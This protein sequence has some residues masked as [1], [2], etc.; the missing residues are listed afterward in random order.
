MFGLSMA[1]GGLSQLLTPT[2][3]TGESGD[4]DKSYIM[5]GLPNLYEQ[6]N[7]VPL[8]YGLDVLCG[9]VV[10]GHAA[11]TYDMTGVQ[12]GYSG[13][14]LSK[15]GVTPSTGPGSGGNGGGT[16]NPGNDGVTVVPNTMFEYLVDFVTGNDPF[17][18][19]GP[20][21]V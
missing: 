15:Y 7:P 13:G 11:L 14:F 1:L 9:S 10:I 4:K 6:G 16:V 17:G 5:S 19:T 20:V 18:G 21:S 12:T 2:P 3:K 8:A